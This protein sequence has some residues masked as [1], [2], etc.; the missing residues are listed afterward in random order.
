MAILTSL[1]Y[2]AKLQGLDLFAYLRDVLTRI[3]AHPASRLS[4]LLPNNWSPPTKPQ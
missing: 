1:I 4:E 3:A 2:S